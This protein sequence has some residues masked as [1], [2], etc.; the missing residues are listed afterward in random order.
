VAALATDRDHEANA[1]TVI[2][3]PP[4][5]LARRRR[6]CPASTGT[7]ARRCRRARVGQFAKLGLHAPAQHQAV[8]LVVS[9]YRLLG[10]SILDHR[11]RADR[12]R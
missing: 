12:L 10:F 5:T 7:R 6:G 1:A 11:V 2:G 3:L 9:V 4:L 8:K